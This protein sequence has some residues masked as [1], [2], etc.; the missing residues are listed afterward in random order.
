MLLL[1]LLIMLIWDN[2]P[3]LLVAVAAAAVN[4]SNAQRASDS[5]SITDS[6]AAIAEGGKAEIGALAAAD[7]A[8]DRP[9]PRGIEYRITSIAGSCTVTTRELRSSGTS[10]AVR[11]ALAAALSS[12]LL[13]EEDDDARDA[14]LL[15]LLLLWCIIP[16]ATVPVCVRA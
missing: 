11:E 7:V 15:L 6:S 1:L 12:P 8:L 2:N 4:A 13:E 5:R 14:V 16:T 9:L 10:A 3:S